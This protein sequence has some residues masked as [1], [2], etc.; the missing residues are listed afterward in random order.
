V[1]VSALFSD[2]FGGVPALANPDQVT[3]LEEDRITAYYGAGTLY[4]SRQR[5]ESLL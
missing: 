2:Q 5:T 3:L 4:A 1:H